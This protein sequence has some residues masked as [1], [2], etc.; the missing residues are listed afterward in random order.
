MIFNY[1]KNN[2]RGKC[3]ITNAKGS[4]GV[5]N[6]LHHIPGAGVPV[7]HHFETQGVRTDSSR[8][9]FISFTDPAQELRVL[10]LYLA[11]IFFGTTP[12]VLYPYRKRNGVLPFI[13]RLLEP[14]SSIC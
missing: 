8:R 6:T 13:D 2:R 1:I 3:T 9:N 12:Q 11:G 7:R 14:T 4:A 5:G 10:R